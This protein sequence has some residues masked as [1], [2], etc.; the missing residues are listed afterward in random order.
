MK[1]YL[2][3]SVFA[4]S[5]FAQ[6]TNDTLKIK[7]LN[8]V[9]ITTSKL[10]K[11]KVFRSQKIESINQKVIEFQNFQTTADI[12]SNSGFAT[13]QKSQQG[14][15]SPILRGF[16]ASRILLLVDGVRMNNLI[17]RAG[18]LQNSITVDKN[19]LE[20]IDILY[21]SGSTLFGSDALGGAINMT[22]K[23]VLFLSDT[24][25]KFSGNFLSRYATVNQEKA[26]HVDLNF[27]NHNFASLT[28]LSLT[29]FGDLMM[30][31]KQNHKNPFFGERN[32]YV[33]TTNGVDM[34][35]PNTNKYLQK[36]SAFKQYDLMQKLAVKQTNGNQHT[37]NFQYSTTTNINRFDRLM[38]VNASGKLSRTK[39]YYGPQKRLLTI[40][41]FSKEKAFLT[42][43]FA[44]NFSYQNV[45]ESRFQRNFGKYDLQN[46][47]E[48][49]AMYSVDVL[50][51]KKF[52][53][54]ELNYGFE[55]YFDDLKSVGF[56]NNINT[57]EI[58]TISTRYPNGKN[59][60]FRNDLFA[61][62]N[63]SIS[64]KTNWNIGARIGYTTLKSTISDNT[65]FKLPF[66]SINQSNITYSGNIGI[67]HKPNRNLNLIANISSGFR[68]PNID[69]LAKIFE[70]TKGAVIVPNE[71]LKP[72]KTISTDVGYR[73]LSDSKRFEM[74][75]NYFYTKF[76]DAIVTDNFTFYG[77]A[78]IDY[79]GKPSNVTASQNKGKANI[80]GISSSL[81]WYLIENLLFQT[82]INYSVGRI[83]ENANQP[84]D[85]IAPL[86]GRVGLSYSKSNFSM[87]AYLLYNG[88]KS[89]KD[90]NSNGEDNQEYAPKD[91]MPSW[92]TYNI[93]SS[94]TVLKKCTLFLGVENI[95][96][97]QYRTFA[98]GMN[99][100]G[101]NFYTGLKYSF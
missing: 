79:D 69:D 75:T 2:L 13:V 54:I 89:I 90:F 29:D 96:D 60:M 14:G 77:S 88:K 55:S 23:K 42:S 95:L 57:G 62:F 26:G 48:K 59:S 16:E 100:P 83:T 98:S 22:T 70:S 4:L 73:F 5:T 6:T 68:V 50:V 66:T 52:T 41:N 91:G 44:I 74:E 49:V 7:K 76:T 87:D 3:V 71:N 17:F 86:F 18:H 51:K 47:I 65:F 30:G 25:N 58:K 99:A 27:A 35:V 84:L 39:W 24:K 33:Q 97:T 38:D 15:G 101:R 46:R 20:N 11:S 34:I 81:K 9:K 92:Q 93:K 80:T 32:F 31:K 45:D 12:L 82:T 19:M 94:F 43:D 72:E 67:I 37:L 1:L 64:N 53:K 21:G 8:E 85:H 63:N 10:L 78:I 56:S 61:V 28:S 36:P 40:Y